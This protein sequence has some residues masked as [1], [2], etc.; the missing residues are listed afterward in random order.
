[1]IIR[2]DAA[3]RQRVRERL[4]SRAII[5]LHGPLRVDDAPCWNFDKPSKSTGYGQ[6]SVGRQKGLL[7]HRVAYE[8]WYGEIPAGTEVDH[9]CRNRACCNPAHLEAVTHRVNTL[10]GAAP[11]AVNAVKTECGNG[12]KF[13]SANTYIDKRGSRCC[14]ACAR[15]KRRRRVAAGLGKYEPKPPRL[16]CKRGHDWTPENTYIRPD[17]GR[18][19]CVA[20]QRIREKTFRGKSPEDAAA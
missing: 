11:S 4:L 10:R 18:R 17:N 12:H 8:L 20:C 13:T 19:L 3:H 1:M 5:D 9:V 7:A 6:F 14:R 16:K 15:D 2:G